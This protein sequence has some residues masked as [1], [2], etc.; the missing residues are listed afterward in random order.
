MVFPFNV[1]G[2]AQQTGVAIEGGSVRAT[3]PGQLF[4]QTGIDFTI[5][6]AP[7]PPDPPPGGTGVFDGLPPNWP[8]VYCVYAVNDWKDRAQTSPE[9]DYIDAGAAM[10]V[11]QGRGIY[12]NSQRVETH[13]IYTQMRIDNPDVRVFIHLLNWRFEINDDNI[14]AVFEI[15]IDHTADKRG[16]F[17]ERERLLTVYFFGPSDLRV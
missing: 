7:P 2:A 3:D 14:I 17:D 4:A 5:L 12:S 6:A 9:K 10:F 13:G 1:E 15:Q 11:W 8:N 16:M